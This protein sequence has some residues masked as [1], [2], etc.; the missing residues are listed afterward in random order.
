LT[1]GQLVDGE[2]KHRFDEMCEEGASAHLQNQHVPF[3]IRD[4]EIPDPTDKAFPAFLAY[5]ALTGPALGA[6]YSGIPGLPVGFIAQNPV[7]FAYTSPDRPPQNTF[8]LQPVLA[9]H[10]WHEWYLRSVKRL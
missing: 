1:A 8:E 2:A 10:L 7:S 9:L 3:R 5:F 6:I 4:Y